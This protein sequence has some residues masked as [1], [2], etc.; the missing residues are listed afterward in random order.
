MWFP[1]APCRIAK[2]TG[3]Q[4]LQLYVDS[5]DVRW[6]FAL[7][8]SAHSPFGI[9]SAPLLAIP[10]RPSDGGKAGRCSDVVDLVLVRG[11]SLGAWPSICA[12]RES[13]LW[14]Y[15]YRGVRDTRALLASK[16][17]QCNR[18]RRTVYLFVNFGRPLSCAL[19]LI[20]LAY[21]AVVYF[22]GTGCSRDE[23]VLRYPP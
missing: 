11:G 8:V 21:C 12:D 6:N 15:F 7:V 2:T 20:R 18:Q 16:C 9:S 1:I 5:R 13:N 22:I 4:G 10:L 3:A 19:V 17:S 14:V 23:L